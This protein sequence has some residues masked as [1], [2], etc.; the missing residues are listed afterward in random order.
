MESVSIRERERLWNWAKFESSLSP[1]DQENV[2]SLEVSLHEI[3]DLGRNV[4]VCWAPN[5]ASILLVS[6][7]YYEITDILSESNADGSS[8]ERAKQMRRVIEAP[9]QCSEES[10]RTVAANLGLNVHRVEL[11]FSPGREVGLELVNDLIRRYAITLDRDRAVA[12]FDI[13]EFSLRSPMEQVTQLNSLSRSLNLAQGHLVDRSLD[14]DFSR[15]TTGDGFYVWNRGGSSQANLNLYHLMHLALADNAIGRPKARSASTP[16]MR[17]CFHVGSFYEFFQPEGLSPTMYDYIVGD[18]TIEVARLI[19]NAKPGQILVGDFRL[20]GPDGNPALDT[21]HFIDRTRE[22]MSTL[23]GM[24]LAGEQVE[25][26]KCYLTGSPRPDGAFGIKQ[27]LITD[28][29]GIKHIAYNAKIN[30][31]LRGRDPIF[32]GLQDGDVDGMQVVG[33]ISDDSSDAMAS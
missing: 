16:L 28:K 14:I 15:S 24:S 10:L 29:H 27:Y 2:A 21:V 13:V 4:V 25:S 33:E 20:P 31:H 23:E 1:E 17:S 12:L 5:E 30:L 18:A 19:S 26:I 8:S 6:V 11:P 9:I 22:T 7:R 3:W 32:L